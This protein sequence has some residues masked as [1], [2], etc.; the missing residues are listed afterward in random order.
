MTL[1]GEPGTFEM[2]ARSNAEREAKLQQIT[3]DNLT[4]SPLLRLPPELRNKIHKDIFSSAVITVRQPF[5]W[6]DIYPGANHNHKGAIA[7]LETC[8]QVNSEVSGMYYA[9]S[10]FNIEGFQVLKFPA[11][12]L[13]RASSG[14]L[15]SIEMCAWSMYL[16]STARDPH[17]WSSLKTVR[18]MDRAGVL[19]QSLGNV[20]ATVRT[21]FGIQNL[22]VIVVRLPKSA[23]N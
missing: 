23:G 17:L 10:T 19:H 8:R 21:W 16:T 18:L 9:L 11:E 15:I 13:P 3:E 5:M 2:H 4:N 7:F 14:K 20:V 1:I 22:E 6:H 12:A